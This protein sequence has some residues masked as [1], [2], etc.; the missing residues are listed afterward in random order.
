MQ[1]QLSQK[2]KMALQ[3]QK[4]QEELCV[5]KYKN[6]S[7]QAQDPELKQ[8]FNTLSSEE[9]KH[10]DTVNQLLQGIQPSLGQGQSGQGGGQSSQM[11]SQGMQSAMMGGQSSSSQMASQSNQSSGQMGSQSMQSG[12]LS[13]KLLCS[14]MLSTEKY[15]SSTYDS[16]IFEAANPAVRQA[17]QHIQKDEQKHGEQIFQYMHSHGMYPVM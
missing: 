10:Y 7:Q 13:D 11:G 12:Q 5:T 3:D 1:I 6:Y 2:E 8:L 14:D 16:G 4:S 17:L 9:Q 15:V